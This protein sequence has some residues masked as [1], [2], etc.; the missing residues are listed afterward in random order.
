MNALNLVQCWWSPHSTD[1]QQR[2]VKINSRDQELTVYDVVNSCF[3]W[4]P[5]EPDIVAA[6]Q[7]TGETLLLNLASPSGNAQ[8][9]SVK[10]QRAC[11]SISFNRDGTKIATGLDKVRN[12]FCLNVWDVSTGSDYSRP[13]RGFA[14]SEAINSVKFTR[15]NP[16]ILIAG[17]TYRYIRLFDIREPPNTPHAITYQSKCVQGIS[18]D[19]DPNYFA[20]Y[21][22]EGVVAVWDRRY[23]KLNS[24]G[25]SSLIFRSSTDDATPASQ[26]NHLRHS[27]TRAGVFAVLN[28]SGGLRVYETAKIMNQ[29]A[30][31]TIGIIGSDNGSE[32]PNHKSRVGGW[33]DSAASLLE[34]GRAYKDGTSTSGTRTPVP[35]ARTDGE[36]LLVTRINDIATASPKPDQRVVC[37]DWMTEG[38]GESRSSTLKILSMKGDGS[39][40][41]L[42]CAGS[43]PSLAWG[44]R[45]EF[46]IT[47]DNDVEI[48]P[49]PSVNAERE[50]V[51]RPRKKS[52]SDLE[53][54]DEKHLHSY[55]GGESPDQKLGMGMMEHARQRSNS[56]IRPEDFLPEVREVLKN[57]I[58][59]VMKKRVEAGYMMDCSKNAELAMREDQYLEDMWIWLDG[60]AE[61]VASDGMLGQALD[62]S[63][64][65]V[66]SVWNGG[67]GTTPESRISNTKRR[68]WQED[69]TA[70][71][72]EI[73]RRH[74]RSKKFPSCKTD[75]PEQRQLCLAICG[76]HFENDELEYEL[77]RLEENDEHSKA[78][79]LALFHG[80]IDRC[81]K[82]LQCGGRALKLMST[83]VAGYFN[84]TRGSSSNSTWKDLAGEMAN[85]LADPYQRA[86]FAYIANSEWREVLDEI[87]IPI[88]ERI[89]IALRWLED[90]ELTNYLDSTTKA[91]VKG[92]ELEGIILT[93]I[94]EASVDLLQEYINRTGDVQTAALVAAF[95]SPRYFRDERV[96]CWMESYRQLLNSWRL[97]H[98]RAKF[99]VAR[100]QAS[101][102]RNGAITM[103]PPQRQVYVRC[104]NCDRSISHNTVGP[105]TGGDPRRAGIAGGRQQVTQA[106]GKGTAKPT[107]CPHCRKSLP[108]CAICLLNLGTAYYK[109][110][111]KS[112]EPE[113]DYDRWFNFCLSCNHG[114]HAGHAKEWFEKHTV[115]PVPDCE[116]RCKM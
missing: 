38:Y 56:I 103:N 51:I 35:M 79:G 86:I 85:E 97:F 87:G 71:C 101:R 36:T 17:V 80:K 108:R 46:A 105:R 95:G 78:A 96:D 40:E 34:A 9:L 13:L 93:G 67:T 73:N 32:G 25:E 110:E 69:W 44:S 50:V 74:Q 20:G 82:S 81:I 53:D 28:S 70:T 75:F 58:C 49:A 83:A 15:D 45:N 98:A 52:I 4:S 115:C 109:E 91:A 24:S 1:T 41:V 31:T 16:D 100:G 22:A 57:D 37:F 6:G 92:G 94:T 18:L 21:H 23:S 112:K 84:S 62:L 10:L 77:Q 90:D 33:R 2:F 64:L 26:I 11:N 106:A 8:S 30:N 43:V 27:S 102:D 42:R 7:S 89:G 99:D 59:M 48:M 60:A 5:T 88:R 65:G 47:S 114:L 63:F 116:C 14:A 39:M 76:S 68:I 12:D 19:L 54:L 3:D 72:D 104:A 107:V 29:E 113:Q 61:C 55:S 111:E 66:H